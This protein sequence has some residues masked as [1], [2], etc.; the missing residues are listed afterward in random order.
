[1]LSDSQRASLVARLR[2]GRADAA[3]GIPRR[4]EGLTH[5]PLSYGQQQLWFI[6]HLAPDQSTYNIAG[7]LWLEGA[8]DVDALGRAVDRLPARHEILRTR[9]VAVDGLPRQVIDQA[10][11]RGLAVVD[12]TCLDQQARDAEVKRLFA[13]EGGRTFSLAEG[14]LVRTTLVRTAEDTH[15]LVIVVHH[16]VF[17]GWSFG[18]LTNE[19]VALYEA[20]ITGAEAAVEEL[21]IQFADYAVW[22]QERLQGT[23]LD[24]LVG[25]WQK[26]LAG[27]AGLQLPTD[28]PRPLVQTYD[29]GVEAITFDKELLDGLKAISRTGNTTLFVALMAAFQVLLHRFSGQDDVVVGTVSA[30]RS[31]SELAPLIGYLVNTL[32]IRSDLSGDPTFPDLLDQVRTTVLDA[33]A[34]QDLPF[35]KLV[36]AL[37]VHRD[38]SRHP[39][40]Q[41]GFTLA[42]SYD[43]ELR[44]HDLVVRQEA[45][46]GTAAKFDLLLSAVDYGDHLAIG[47]SYASA[48]FDGE[49]VRRLLG[50]FG[51]LLEGI[52][53]DVQR[54]L[55]RLPLLSEADRRREIVEWNDSAAE[56]PS[57][58]LHEKFQAQVA[59]TPDGKAVEL[60]GEGLTYTEL[61]ARAN[62]L[63]RRLRE[64]GAGPEV[65]VG[66]CMQRSVDRMVALM[67]ILKAGSGYVPLDP[68]Y[69]A[70]RLAFMVEDAHMP[71]VVT[72]EL[73]AAAAPAAEHVLDVDGLGEELAA[74][75]DSNPEYL[76]DPANV[77]YVIYTSGSTGRPKGVVI[78]HR[79]AVNFATGEIEH[80]PLGPGDRVLQ[81]ASLN[82]DVSVLDMFG[83]LLSGAT[84]VLGRSET[85]LSPPRL[86][87]LIRDE[88]ITFMCLPPAVL[89]LLADE[90]FPDLRVVIAG[91]EAFSS[92]LVQKWARPGMRF[93][94]GY[95]PTETT[96][97]ATM[98]E[99]TDNGIDPPPIGLPLP[100]YTAYVLDRN[101]E[102]LPIGVAGELHLGGAGVAR[103]YL[104]R[105]E[106]TEEKFIPDP[107]SDVPGARLYKTGD[108]ARRMA[109]GNI[110]FLGRFDDQVK[111]RGLRVELGE[112]EAVLALHPDVLQAA[113]VV[114]ED[115]AGQKQLVGYARV[116]PDRTAPTPADLRLHM[117]DRLPGFMV[118]Q[119]VL[120][121]DKFPLNANGKVD[122]GKLPAPE[123]GDGSANYAPPRTII[124]A[125]LTDTFG[126]LLKLPRVGVDDSF[127]DLGGNS[128]QAMQLVTR[129]RSELAVDTDVT[130]I[131][132]APTTAQL[133]SVL[134]EKHGL[135][136]AP[137]DEEDGELVVD[138]DV[139]RLASAAAGSGPLVRL[140]D[141][142]GARPLYLIHA[143]GGT[144]YGY[145]SL[146]R[147]LADVYEVWGIE[148]QGLRADGT[149]VASL[150]AMVTR[151]TEVIRAAQPAGPYRLGGWSFGGLVALKVAERL[152]EAGEQ[153]SFVALM[154]A[155][156]QVHEEVTQ[157]EAELAG[158]YVADA[159]RTLGP[160]AAAAPDPATASSAEQLRWLAEQL[161][162]GS[163]D[164]DVL[165]DMNRRFDVYKAHLRAIA[166]YTPSV[167]DVETVVVNAEESAADAEAWSQALP[168]VVRSVVVPGDHY[169]FLRAPG[170]L[171][172][173][174]TLRALATSD[175]PQLSRD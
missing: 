120:V 132:L 3:V 124:E 104:N 85:L 24:D 46:E 1:M 174:A 130:A 172:V 151:Y 112:I 11:P 29:G 78:E 121:L 153:V 116:D 91:G 22:E 72:D 150:D 40:F 146:A 75:D 9:L 147:E 143:I 136:D 14:P 149:P 114:R 101:L 61:N 117:A 23:V 119:Y 74:L 173:A 67:G 163:D 87:E 171:E 128:L 44:A 141:G 162:R 144:V 12:L 5:I 73:S 140:S 70:D 57:W 154:D 60:A 131:F 98:L 84:L 35:A 27:V 158:Y 66:V 71:I 123:A 52:V 39:I 80:W 30:N 94:N 79:Q 45:I 32:A 166:N 96:V 95:G 142:A 83:A 31:R 42:E 7:A 37:R 118:P 56:Y 18:V 25:Y 103:G 26:K 53:A 122:R 2:K 68:E 159:A 169:S 127:F 100:N 97:G 38:P 86:A 81:F 10:A 93:I 16:T 48:L 89:N 13:E 145:V 41:V 17:D 125:V 161:A 64:L 54:P 69:P 19:L 138:V 165:A 4:P 160:N 105:P 59:A 8:L 62:Q 107:F 6:D 167:I 108:V 47:A 175:D 76:V 168:N 77:A 155:P 15:A 90:Q 164:A 152:R 82:F 51:V 134:R 133:A 157:T 65:L 129:L 113:I 50:H 156:F 63:A 36:D 170:V 115:Q 20:E 126:D 99:C 49:T 43:T 33:Y 111:I 58:A 110:Q 137:L 135:E 148:A 109:D 88:H 34:H 92:A 106:L 102:P 55:S 28:R 139:D 21:A